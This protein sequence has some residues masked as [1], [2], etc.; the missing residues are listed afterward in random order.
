[1]KGRVQRLKDRDVP[2]VVRLFGQVVDEIHPKSSDA[3]RQQFKAPYSRRG[4]ERRMHDRDGVYLVAK[5][6]GKVVGF[7]FGWIWEGTG[8][9]RWLGVAE[10]ARGLGLG[11]RLVERALQHFQSRK[12]HEVKVFSYPGFDT[13]YKFFRKLG[14]VQKAHIE[15]EFFGTAVILMLK[16]LADVPAQQTARKIVLAGEAGQGIK[17]MANALATVLAKMGKEVSLN[18]VYGP[19]VRGGDIEAELIFSDEPIDVP[20]IERADVRVQLSKPSGER[21]NARRVLIEQSVCGRKECMK[22]DFRCPASERVP[23]S[24][25]AVKEFGSP[26]FIN[27][28]A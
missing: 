4:I 9:I 15:K 7:L 1:M 12:C 24:R 2:A 17:L 16:K 25:L 8:H 5:V 23:F 20:F 19:A 3:T 27:M 28:I 21:F 18:L 10:N 6:K 26:L 13:L 22:C 11:T 14:F